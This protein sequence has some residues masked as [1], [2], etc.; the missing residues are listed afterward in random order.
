[1]CI[2]KHKSGSTVQEEICGL[3]IVV[4]AWVGRSRQWDC[5]YFIE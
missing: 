5:A 4:D 2:G 1:M 3:G